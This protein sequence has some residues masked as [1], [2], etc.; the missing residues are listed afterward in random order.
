VFGVIPQFLASSS[1]PLDWLPN[2]SPVMLLHGEQYLAIKKWPIPTSGTVIQ[3]PKVMEVLDKGKAAAVTVVVQTIEKSSGEAWFENQSTVFIRGS[4]G[5][6]GK[7]TGK[8]RG[9]A[10][11][12]NKPPSRKADRVVEEKTLERQAAIYRLSGDY[13]PLHIDPEFAAV[14]GFKSPILHGLCFM[15]IA[16]KHVYEAYGP[17]KD[18]KVRFAGH[19]FPGETIVTE[20][21]KEGDKVIFVA[22]SKERG[23]TVLSNAA[24][25]LRE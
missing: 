24:A 9:A 1:L 23:T 14:G 13:N 20:M 25:T 5:F 16:G 2:F 18:I 10:S 17:I 15:G 6:G 12:L 3:Q 7:K 11:A 8:D 4:G 22:K 21:W 19:V